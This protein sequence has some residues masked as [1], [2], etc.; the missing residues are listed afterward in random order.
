VFARISGFLLA[1]SWDIKMKP[2]P[3]VFFF[4][5]KGSRMSRS[6]ESLCSFNCANQ[7][8]T[9]F[10]G[11]ISCP[12]IIDTLLSIA[13]FPISWS[14]KPRFKKVEA[15]ASSTHFLKFRYQHYLYASFAIFIPARQ[16]GLANF[17]VL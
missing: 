7:F 16:V 15:L 8:Q 5:Q 13:F 1:N 14:F 6:E 9:Q 17:Q 10:V 11:A 2:L 4:P 12:H 3:P